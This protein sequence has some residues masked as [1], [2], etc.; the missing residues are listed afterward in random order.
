MTMKKC[1]LIVLSMTMLAADALL[2]QTPPALPPGPPPVGDAPAGPNVFF[3]TEAPSGMPPM[4]EGPAGSNV[5][6]FRRPEMGI[7]QSLKPV[8]NAPYQAEAETKTT[9]HLADGNVIE[10]DHTSK[11]ARDKQGRTWTEET[12]DHM[13]PWSSQ[14][15]SPKTLVFIFDPVAGYSYTLHPD[16]KTAERRTMPNPQKWMRRANGDVKRGGSFEHR[17]FSRDST[18]AELDIKVEKLGTQQVNGVAAQGKRTTHTL[19][20]NTIGNTLPIVDT[21]E[22]WFSSDLQMVVESKRSDPRFGDTTFDLKNIQKGDPPASLFQV[23]GDY[24]VTDARSFA[25]TIRT[26]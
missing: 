16:R 13:G 5:V 17:T 8:L 7:H 3:L 4:T 10:K 25:R 11:M 18:G 23:P 22:S 6:F 21:N 14:N 9:Q 26:Q 20:A 2:A 24:T 19:P 1:N 12:I 15:N